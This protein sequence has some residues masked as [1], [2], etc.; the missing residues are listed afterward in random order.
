MFIFMYYSVVKKSFK[1]PNKLNVFIFRPNWLQP[2]LNL[3]YVTEQ[4]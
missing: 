4:Y 2:S 3:T 1:Q